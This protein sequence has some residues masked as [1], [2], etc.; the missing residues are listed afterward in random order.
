M[1]SSLRAF[2]FLLRE[3]AQSLSDWQMD[4]LALN[5]VA[6]TTPARPDMAGMT[7]AHMFWILSYL[8]EAVS[9]LF[10]SCWSAI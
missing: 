3:D 2:A 7:L 5:A 6:D 8:S 4:Q 9:K 10:Q 1:R